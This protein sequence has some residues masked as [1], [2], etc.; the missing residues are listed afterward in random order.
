MRG[1]ENGRATQR[2]IMQDIADYSRT[3]GIDTFKRL[4]EEEHFGTVQNGSRQGYLFAH[5]HRIVYNQLVGI[6][7]ER[8]YTQ[9]FF[10][11]SLDIC[12][13]HTIHMTGKDK[14]FPPR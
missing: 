13:G 10:R 12:L 9:Q 4:I 8:Q 14:K 2:E 7:G 3:D 1:E 5:P 11:A 6:L